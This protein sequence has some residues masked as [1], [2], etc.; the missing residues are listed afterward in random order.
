MGKYNSS[1][2][3]TA[4]AELIA[5]TLAG[6]ES[7]IFS[8]VVTSSHV[9]DAGADLANLTSLANVEQTVLPSSASVLYNNVVQ[10]TARFDNT[11]ISADYPIN[12]I[13]LYAKAGESG[14]PVLLA[15]TTAITADI[16]PAYNDDTPSAFIYN[17]LLTIQSASEINI[18]VDPAGAVSIAD[19]NAFRTE[20]TQIVNSALTV[21]EVE[22]P[23]TAWSSS[24][25]YTQTVAV[26]G[27]TADS[28]PEVYLI[29]PSTITSS[30]AEAY[31]EAYSYVNKVE[32]SDGSITVTAFYSKPSVDLTI[33]LKGV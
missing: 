18:T 5:S 25:P 8:S 3:T 19:F 7:L 10:I 14:T 28:M 24:A 2:I 30:N 33:A 4:G 12:A 26:S 22:L 32:T 29:Y 27:I 1:V 6:G 9:Y 17:I 16:Q 21:R 15:V 31:V 23:S 20:I 13:G 11:N